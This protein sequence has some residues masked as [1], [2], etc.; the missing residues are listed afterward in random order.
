T[1][2]EPKFET[3]VVTDIIKTPY[4]IIKNTLELPFILFN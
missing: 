2:D 4:N 1:L 3:Q